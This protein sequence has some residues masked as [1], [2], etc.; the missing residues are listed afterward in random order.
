MAFLAFENI[1]I[2]GISSIVPENRID[3]SNETEYF[4]ETELKKYIG[5]VGVR[6]RNIA[7]NITTT[8]DLCFQAAE[9]LIEK[10]SIDRS[11]I[12]MLLFVSQTPDYILPATAI[13]LQ[14][15]LNLNKRCA[16]FDINLG[17]SGFVYG[18]SVAYSYLQQKHIKKVLLLCGDTPSKIVSKKDKSASLLFG[19]SGTATIIES[20]RVCKRAY[21]TLNSDGGGAHSLNIRGGAFRN[22]VTKKTINAYKWRDGN[23]RSENQLFMD[24]ME[25]FNFV[26]EEVENDINFLLKKSE[27]LKE[28]IDYFLFHQANLLINNFLIKKMKLDPAKV[29]SSLFNYGNTSS[30]SIPVTICANLNESDMSGKTLLA[31]GFGV[32]LSWASAILDFSHALIMPIKEIK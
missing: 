32:G 11:E 18:L 6:Y 26:M 24:G 8:S 12:D 13:I 22:V 7:N 2:T 30:A 17:C 19:D 14:D 10:M 4:T 27:I 31:N 20:D 15:R 23:I 16:A 1:C 3:N 21:F 9:N 28:E 25:I 29:P 5:T